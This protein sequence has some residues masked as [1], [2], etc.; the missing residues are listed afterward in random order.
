MGHLKRLRQTTL[1][2]V[3]VLDKHVYHFV[4]ILLPLLSTSHYINILTVE[5]YQHFNFKKLIY[6][7]KNARSSLS[8]YVRTRAK[9]DS[10]KNWA[11]QQKSTEP[12]VIDRRR[13]GTW[14]VL[15]GKISD[16]HF[17]LKKIKEQNRYKP[18]D[19][20]LIFTPW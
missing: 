7:R 4:C 9:H 14:S 8:L 3:S 20:R 10:P 12:K 1:L 19:W 5:I 6:Y 17:I 16:R 11:D 15:F 18:T 13:G 2:H